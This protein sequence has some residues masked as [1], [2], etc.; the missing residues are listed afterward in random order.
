MKNRITTS[1][2]INVKAIDE[3][4]RSSLLSDSFQA[5]DETSTTAI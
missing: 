4:V 3:I 2:R 5:N 1:T